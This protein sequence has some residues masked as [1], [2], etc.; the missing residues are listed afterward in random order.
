MK[1]D[2]AAAWLWRQKICCLVAVIKG[3]PG[4]FGR[5]PLGQSEEW[6]HMVS[7]PLP[8]FRVQSC[9]PVDRGELSCDLFLI[10]Y[11]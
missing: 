3:F 7:M 1:W 6:K 10:I 11:G 2:M 4:N 9:P 5:S 8:M